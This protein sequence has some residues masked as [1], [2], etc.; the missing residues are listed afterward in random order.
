MA[1]LT[2][3]SPILQEFGLSGSH[4]SDGVNTPDDATIDAALAR[5]Y[6]TTNAPRYEVFQEY[7]SQ[8]G[9]ISVSPGWCMAVIRLAKPLT[10]SRK[11]NRSVGDPASG[12]FLRKSKPLII[13]EDCLQLSV[14]RPMGSPTKTL[15]AT[16]KSASVNY[17]SANAVLPGDWIL[18][19]CHNDIEY[20]KK[21]IPRILN[22][23]ACNK[24]S[25]GLKFIGR[26]HNIR[27]HVSVSEK[28][29]TASY[30]IQAIGFSELETIFYYDVHLATAAFMG[31][32][33]AIG[34]FMNQIGLNYIDFINNENDNSGN[35]ADNI[36]KIIPALVDS[37]IGKGKPS[38]A[39]KALDENAGP[40]GSTV[41]TQVPS[42]SEARYSYLVPSFVAK[43]LGKR[44]TDKSREIPVFA[45]ADLF[46]LLI[47]VQQ[48]DHTKTDSPHKGFWPVVDDTKSGE[49]RSI[50]P[51]PLKGTFLPQA[52][53]VANIPLWSMIAEQF[54][55][56]AINRCYTALKVGPEGDIIPTIVAR[57]MPFSSNVAVEDPGVALTRLLHLPRWVI[58]PVM[59]RDIDV[60]RSDAYK[61]N[62][63]KV[64]GDPKVFPQN[65]MSVPADE[66]VR[67]PPVFD[68]VDIARC[69]IKPYT[70][71]INCSPN[72]IARPGGLSTWIKIVADM[73][74]GAQ[75]S[76]NGTIQCTGIQTPVA[77][78]DNI[79]F[80]GIVY[81]IDSISD[82]CNISPAG[83]TFSTTFSVT[84]GMPVEQD[85]EA[86]FPTYPGFSAMDTTLA[87]P[88]YSPNG[89]G[90][91][92]VLTSQDPGMS[93]DK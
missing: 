91:D 78:G 33:A 9:C 19:W 84:H 71:I 92:D 57:Q 43:L 31:G 41:H 37:V 66:M 62:M 46:H 30:S 7:G 67:N 35:I 34:L 75:Y 69:G 73:H 83:K 14:T 72:D 10:Y 76:L 29:R 22:G 54:I 65:A 58:S 52:I 26:V 28:A 63:I 13:F 23:E 12:A 17:L 49:N 51:N 90:N 16:L 38:Q 55:N 61:F 36:S 18:A 3:L 21:L 47:G 5:N 32:A 89:R 56:P 6:R 68:T 40:G 85:E 53:E 64:L 86:D 82:Y 8:D 50:L 11:L 93:E 39:N 70:Q 74:L 87:D 4:P 59:V 15:N 25:D 48:Y 88:D 24:F 81:H 80:E 44:D 79:E 1:L 20:T 42:S 45:C 77:E 27:K 2:P 60:G